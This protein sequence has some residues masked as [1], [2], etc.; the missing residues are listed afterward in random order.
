[1]HGV[2]GAVIRAHTE[3]MHMEKPPSTSPVKRNL[4][5]W[6][7]PWAHEDLKGHVGHPGVAP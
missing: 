2:C 3:R 7:G 1:M 6:N 5:D 4:R